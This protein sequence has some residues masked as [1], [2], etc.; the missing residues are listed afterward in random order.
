MVWDMCHKIIETVFFDTN[1]NA[2]MYMNM[3]HNM[4]MPSLLNK[5]GEFLVYFQQ[6]GAPPHYGIC[7][8]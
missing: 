6:D 7:V 5:D 4:I 8:W 2:E 1:L 3:L